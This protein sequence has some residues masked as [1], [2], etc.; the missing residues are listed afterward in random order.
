MARIYVTRRETFSAAHRLHSDK[1]S[2]EENQELFGPCNN[3]HGHG[4]N[5]SI[6]V[7]VSGTP[8]PVTG[9]VINISD[10]KLIMKDK[11]MAVLD[12]K[13]IDKQVDYFRESGLVSTTEN[14]ALFCWKQLED[15]IP[16]PARLHQVKIWETD[17][18]IVTY[19]GE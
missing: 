5:Y 15:D 1:L 17:K 18:N 8:D 10:L 2:Q 13:N 14:L 7:T 11:I 3:L 16:S 4:H 6:E 12:H 9:M 19:N